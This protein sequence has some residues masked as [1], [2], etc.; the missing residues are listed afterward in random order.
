M[1]SSV[2]I[3]FILTIMML[4]LSY[5]FTYSFGAGFSKSRLIKLNSNTRHKIHDIQYGDLKSVKL[6]NAK[7]EK[8]TNLV[9]LC[10]RGP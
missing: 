5:T 3:S 1:R 4:C 6:L 2:F 9:D 8:R 10:S 7:S